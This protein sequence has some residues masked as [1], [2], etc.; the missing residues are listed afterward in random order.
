[1]ARTIRSGGIPDGRPHFEPRR[2][3]D[4]RHHTSLATWRSLTRGVPRKVRRKRYGDVLCAGDWADEAVRK[5]E[6]SRASRLADTEAVRLGL[7]E[8]D[9]WDC[10]GSN[11][12]DEYPDDDYLAWRIR[13]EDEFYARNP[14]IE[15]YRECW[16]AGVVIRD[17]RPVR[18]FPAVGEGFRLGLSTRPT[19]LKWNLDMDKS[20]ATSPA[21][22]R[23]TAKY[24]DVVSTIIAE[25]AVI[26]RMPSDKSPWQWRV[27]LRDERVIGDIQ[28]FSHTFADLINTL[29]EAV[30]GGLRS[31]MES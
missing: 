2:S 29:A 26:D 28:I 25:K 10:F 19:P 4:P 5:R 9:E 16:P 22:E 14:D 21:W 3:G 23:P 15:R 6:N 12:D 30:E 17:K 31:R 24:Y 20:K 11:S 1:M 13:A 27:T 18:L 8:L 7:A